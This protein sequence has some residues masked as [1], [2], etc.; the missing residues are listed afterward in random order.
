MKA[1]LRVT[2]SH[3]FCSFH[4]QKPKI[5]N[6]WGASWQLFVQWN[7]HTHC[8]K[9]KKLTLVN[10]MANHQS[11]YHSRALS[12][13]IVIIINIII[14]IIIT[15]IIIGIIIIHPTLSQREVR[16]SKLPP[17]KVKKYPIKNIILWENPATSGS[18]DQ[19]LGPFLSARS[20]WSADNRFQYGVP[21][22]WS[23][24]ICAVL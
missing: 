1:H 7:M 21:G 22:R 11:P 17:C 3:T 16:T 10:I 5:R 8:N 14:I 4:R 24:A 6:V 23:C 9:P 15:I 12:I 2:E 20:C 19:F 18:R 13:I